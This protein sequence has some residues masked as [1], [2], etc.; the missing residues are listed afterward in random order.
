MSARTCTIVLVFTTVWRFTVRSD[1]TEEF[2][3]HYGPDGTWAA[4]FRNGAGYIG[5]QLFKSTS[6]PA[7]YVTV[8]TWE[9]EAA[10]REFRAAHSSAYEELDARLESLTT[11]ETLLGQRSS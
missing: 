5:T 8:D 10:F 11:A 7:E 9:S 2:E 3:R 1:R 4:L 6:V